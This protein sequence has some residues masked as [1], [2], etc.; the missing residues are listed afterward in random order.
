MVSND[1]LKA[2]FACIRKWSYRFVNDTEK[3]D[4]N[5]E[6]GITCKYGKIRSRRSY[7]AVYGRKRAWAFDLGTL[8]KDRTEAEDD[9]IKANFSVEANK[10]TRLSTIRAIFPTASSLKY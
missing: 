1:V 9:G 3:Y 10:G 7:L 6:P 5:T 2:N 4:R 8:V